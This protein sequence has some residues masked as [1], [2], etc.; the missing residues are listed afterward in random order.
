MKMKLTAICCMISFTLSSQ[1]LVPVRKIYNATQTGNEKAFIDE[2][3]LTTPANSNDW[4]ESLSMFNKNTS[5]IL[6]YNSYTGAY[7][8][9]ALPPTGIHYEFELDGTYKLSSVQI[10]VQPNGSSNDTLRIK[11][12]LPYNFNNPV[13]QIIDN[14]TL[15]QQ[16]Y[17]FSVSDTTQWLQLTVGEGFGIIKEIKIYGYKLQNYIEPTVN[18]SASK[19]KFD[20]VAAVNMVFQMGQS[21]DGTNFDE[22]I[23]AGARHFAAATYVTHADGTLIHPSGTAGEVEEMFVNRIVGSGTDLYYAMGSMVSAGMVTPGNNS[24]GDWASQKPINTALGDSANG[25]RYGGILTFNEIASNPASYAQAA[26]TLRALAK[27]HKQLGLKYIEPDNEKDGSFK[28]AGYMYPEQLAA[29]ISCYYDG[30]GGTVTFAGDSVGVAG[31]GIKL[32]SPALAYISPRYIES[33]ILWWKFNRPAGYKKFPLDVFS[34]HAY[35]G[36]FELQFTGAGE[37]VAPED[38][39]YNLKSK[40]DTAR[41]YAAIMGVPLWNTESGFD[42][43]PEDQVITS[44]SCPSGTKWGGSFMAIKAFAGKTEEQIQAEWTVRNLLLHASTGTKLF[45]YWLADQYKSGTTCGTFNSAGL[46]RFDTVI[47]WK[48]LYIPRLAY[49]YT[50]ALKGSLSGYVFTGAVHNGSTYLHKYELATDASKKALVYWRATSNGSTAA[51]RLPFAASTSYEVITLNNTTT[52][53]SISGAGTLDLIATE[54]PQIILYSG[55][56][57]GVGKNYFLIN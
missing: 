27:A 12:G 9:S 24:G 26:W 29:M 57:A 32:V 14:G 47:A 15:S 25:Q 49:Y 3:A 6:Q 31:T 22:H 2:Q 53:N 20:S 4:W 54:S 40:L 17:S 50:E 34:V 36:T 37:A 45:I 38:T 41:Y 33:M 56:F 8:T 28:A 30:H 16:W 52:G 18:L 55:G 48:P 1:T 42:C 51:V 44:G 19:M 46:L 11:S 13:G 43:Y 5:V 7:R 23:V 35:P 21:S 10:F 39:I